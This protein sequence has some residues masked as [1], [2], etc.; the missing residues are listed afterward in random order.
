MNIIANGY[1]NLAIAPPAAIVQENISAILS[2]KDDD[3]A[4]KNI[5]NGV[6][7]KHVRLRKIFI[8]KLQKSRDSWAKLRRYQSRT[9]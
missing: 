1:L 8:S 3:E 6:R 4:V 5:V 7:L 9:Q 2:Y